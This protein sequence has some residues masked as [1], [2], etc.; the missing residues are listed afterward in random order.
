MVLNTRVRLWDIKHRNML[1]SFPLWK[2]NFNI[3][4][5]FKYEVMFST[6]LRDKNEVE[7]YS[8]DN[9]SFDGNMT[10]DNTMGL[11]PNG[12]IYDEESIH[13]VVWNGALGSWDLDFDEDEE[14]KYKRDTHMLLRSSESIEIV[15]NIYEGNQTCKK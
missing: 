6:G 2:A 7:I 10:A 13:T 15:G 5:M 8:K 12:Y 1:P 4:D 14:W 3:Y 11:E 9:I